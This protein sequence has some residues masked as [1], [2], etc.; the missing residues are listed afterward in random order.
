MRALMLGYYDE[1]GQLNYVGKVGSGFSE[2]SFL[3]IERR[4]QAIGRPTCP[5]TKTPPKEAGRTTHW[6]L[7]KLIA[8]VRYAGWSTDG[9][10]R[11]P[12]FEGLREDSDPADIT[13]ESVGT[14]DGSDSRPA[15]RGSAQ[16]APAKGGVNDSGDSRRE[17]VRADLAGV[18]LTSP[19][20][21]L[22]PDSGISK[23]DLVKFYLEIGDWI[24]PHVIN[25]PLTLVRCPDGIDAESFFQKHAGRETPSTIHRLKA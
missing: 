23:L 11:H 15:S 25:R 2:E 22:Y 4:L 14:P 1:R 20:K 7:P 13:R 19:G 17:S 10:L 12:T 24:L 8:Q 6:V 9:I 21:V 18:K 3:A 16:A 5:F